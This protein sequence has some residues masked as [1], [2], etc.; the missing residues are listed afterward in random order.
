[1]RITSTVVGISN[2]LDLPYSQKIWRVIK[3]DGLAV[4]GKTAKLKTAKFN[5]RQ[6][7][8]LYGIYLDSQQ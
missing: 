5:D 1:M 3:F 6:C 7:F 4:L 2:V 8:R